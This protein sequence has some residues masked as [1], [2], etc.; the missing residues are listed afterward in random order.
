[1][2]QILAVKYLT[3][4]EIKIKTNATK[5]VPLIFCKHSEAL[6]WYVGL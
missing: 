1:M 2:G 5:S 4:M 3:S 6:L